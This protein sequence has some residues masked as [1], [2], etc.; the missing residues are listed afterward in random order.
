[1]ESST[2]GKTRPTNGIALG[3][4]LLLFAAMSVVGITWGLPSRTIDRYLFG[5]GEVWSG[6]KIYRLAKADGKFSPTRGADVDVDP[7]RK[8]GDEPIPLTAAEEDVAKIYLRYRLYTYQPDEMITMMALAGMR[9]TK[10][11]F[12]PR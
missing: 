3:G 9:P 5:D 10:L 6:E 7:I 11:D 4:I 8:G 1:M 12:D 2:E